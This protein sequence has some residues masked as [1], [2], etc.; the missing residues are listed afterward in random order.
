MIL[1]FILVASSLP[2]SP[3]LSSHPLS[4]FLSSTLLYDQKASNVKNA[5]I[6]I[7]GDK[8][9]SVTLPTS[10]NVAFAQTDN[11]GSEFWPSL[12]I[13]P[14]VAFGQTA[15]SES[16]PS[17]S[18]SLTV[19]A[20]CSTPGGDETPG[21]DT[22]VGTSGD[23]DF[24]GGKG[25]DTIL[26]CEGDDKLFGNNNDDTLTGGPGADEFECGN[27]EDTITDYTPSEGDTIV[28]PENCENITTNE[29]PTLV[30][31]E[32]TVTCGEGDFEVSGEFAGSGAS[33][34]V[35]VGTNSGPIVG[36]ATADANGVW[37]TTIDPKDTNLGDGTFTLIA[38]ANGIDTNTI[39]VTIDCPPTLVGPEG[40]VTCGEGDFEVSGEFAGSGAS[41]VVHV[42]TNSG[43]IVGTATA[44]ANGVW[45]TTIDPKDTNLGDGTFTLIATANGIDTNTI[46]VTIDCP[47]TLVGP[48]GTVTC[49]EGDFEVS[50]E[51]A[52]SG[53]SIVVHV[54]TNS[55][56][57]VGTATADANGVWSTTIDPK[58]T[59]LGDGT[60]TLIAT[61]N[62]IDTN[63]IQVTIDCPPTLVGPE[64]TVTCGEG[65]FEVSGEFAGSGASI[66]VHVGTNSGPIVGTATADA[67]G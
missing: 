67:N 4:P 43:P 27:G 62:G 48:E 46:Q 35:H 2:L 8:S 30:G 55:G 58:D 42:G 63:T 51:F 54:G 47:P 24:N 22:L 36:T 5:Q 11:T 31:P 64:G 6:N 14:N 61:A 57:I 16:Q 45:S 26:G 33:I 66:V 32:G 56:P 10:P 52:G 12:P 59:N 13:F 40:T 23:D 21:D 9:S 15:E 1:F 41:I 29:S 3:V 39:Q 60:F 50:G 53:A 18:F 65:D 25:D 38:T 19:T 17:D 49:G 44:D 37:S 34:V 7:A 20:D 28:D